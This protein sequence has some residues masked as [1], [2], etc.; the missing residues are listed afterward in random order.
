MEL[1]HPTV[2]ILSDLLGPD[3]QPVDLLVRDD[4]AAIVELR[5][6]ELRETHILVTRHGEWVAPELLTRNTMLVSAHRP[7]VSE[8]GEPIV[9]L[10]QQASGWPSSNGSTPPEVWFSLDGTVAEDATAISLATRSDRFQGSV[11]DDGTF[12][13]LVKANRGEI[14]DVQVHLLNGEQ[15]QVSL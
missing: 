11:R 3:W 7:A 9:R 14:P 10:Q 5:R 2:M 8:P 13:V 4:Q 12:L 1:T 15:L 6:G